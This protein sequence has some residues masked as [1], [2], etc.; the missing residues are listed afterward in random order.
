MD[1]M[2]PNPVP[3]KFEPV[4]LPRVNSAD[5]IWREQALKPTESIWLEKPITLPGDTDNAK[6]PAEADIVIIGSGITGASIARFLATYGR[7]LS[8]GPDFMAPCA[9]DLDAPGVKVVMLEA[10]DICSG[11]TGR[12]GAFWN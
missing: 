9:T 2:S 10:R 11:A 8:P 3:E 5:N 6:L 4:T 7:G 1:H 12:D